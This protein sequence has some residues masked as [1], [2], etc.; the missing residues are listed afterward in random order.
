LSLFS[1]L[2][3][4]LS[5]QEH[6]RS[7][8]V[9]LLNWLIEQLQYHVTAQGPLGQQTE[10]AGGELRSFSEGLIGIRNVNIG[11]DRWVNR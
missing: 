8:W 6:W 10:F 7:R 11:K 9:K 4:I 1:P 5:R 3:S 2:G